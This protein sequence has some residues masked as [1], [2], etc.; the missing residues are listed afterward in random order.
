M[1]LRKTVDFAI[2]IFDSP[3][4]IGGASSPHMML[5]AKRVSLILL[6]MWNDFSFTS[7]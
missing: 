6:T 4:G 7:L 5:D 1:K 2:I 3:L